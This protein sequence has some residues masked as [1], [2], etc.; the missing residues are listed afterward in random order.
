MSEIQIVEKALEEL[1]GKVL[2]KVNNLDAMV[3]DLAQQR[4]GYTMMP[5]TKAA[6][7]VGQLALESEQF[8]ALLSGQAK[9]AKVTLDASLATK[10][11][12]GDTGSPPSADDVMSAADRLG[13]IVPGAQRRL[14]V[15]DLLPVA[16]ASSNQVSA[17]R[18]TIYTN[19]AAGQEYEG[20]AAAQSAFTFDLKTLPVVTLTHYV[21][22]SEQVLQDATALRTYIDGRLRY[23]CLLR[24]E[25]QLLTG[26]GT[27]GNL[28]GFLKAGNHTAYSA[29]SGDSATDTIR[30]AI[31]ASQLADY[32]PSAIILHP[33]DWRAIEAAKAT[34]GEY[35]LGNGNARGYL[36]EGMPWQLWGV[37]VVVTSSMTQ[38]KFLL[39]DFQAA[40][41]LWDRQQATVELGYINTQFVEKMVTLRASERVALAVN[42]PA[43]L[44]GGDLTI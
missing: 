28:D 32:E 43:A 13:Y 44:Q 23:G 27:A 3:R 12:T 17:C 16:A 11:I 42:V 39:G 24:E 9:T 25:I 7:S 21:T 19:A 29:A 36:A 20:D 34:G 41:V 18:E 22:A 8:Q 14:R 33:T 4:D 10:S 35:I 1:Q 31:E 38:G 5:G 37:P 6:K 26:D 15:R 2:D 40:A 30:K